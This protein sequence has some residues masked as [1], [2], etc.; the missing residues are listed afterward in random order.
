MVE[1]NLTFGECLDQ[2]FHE[3]D[4]LTQLILTT[5]QSIGKLDDLCKRYS[6]ND[7]VSQKGSGIKVVGWPFRAPFRSWQGTCLGRT[8]SLP[9]RKIE[10]TAKSMIEFLDA[11][12]PQNRT[13]WSV[14]AP[15]RASGVVKLV[16]RRWWSHS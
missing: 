9:S 4:V 7:D 8:S 16:Q 10:A 11:V 3:R 1:T 14:A 12:S 6:A 2:A 13:K 15:M 5:F